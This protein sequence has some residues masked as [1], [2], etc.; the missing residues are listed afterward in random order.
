MGDRAV[1]NKRI[2][3]VSIWKIIKDYSIITIS[4]FLYALTFNF[5]FETNNLAMGGFSGIGQVLHHYF[6]FLTPGVVVFVMNVPLM[7]IGIKKQGMS[8]LFSTV[9]AICV[10]SFMIDAMNVFVAQMGWEYPKMEQPLLACIFGGLLCGASLGLMMLKNATTGGTELAARLLKYVFRNISIGKLC[11]VIDITVVC[12]YA[13]TYGKLEAALYGVIAMYIASIAMD[14]V[15]YGSDSAKLAYIISD[16]SEEITR[17]LMDMGLGA[18]I[19]E[20]RGAFTRNNKPV[21]LCAAKPAKI[22][23]IKAAVV[24]IDPQKSFII[25][26]NVKEVYGEGFGEYTEDNL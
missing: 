4:T 5:F 9:F 14:M 6:A 12:F 20:G 8:I 2:F 15:V 19:L 10:T 11:L 17:R 22:A 18:T 13:I 3:T 26:G 23:R 25:V 21:L 16:K 7:I 1:K 24:E